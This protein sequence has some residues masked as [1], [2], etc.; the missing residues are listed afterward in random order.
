MADNSIFE[1]VTFKLREW[2]PSVL[3]Y[4]GNKLKKRA[5]SS[6][7][8]HIATGSVYSLSTSWLSMLWICL[9]I[10]YGLWIIPL[11]GQLIIWFFYSVYRELIVDRYKNK[12]KPKGHIIAQII[13][14]SAGFVMALPMTLIT[15]LTGILL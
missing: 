11:I 13:E 10:P 12:G 9:H 7:I 2:F 1:I 3:G 8:E 5:D 14:R 6:T 15:I 4:H